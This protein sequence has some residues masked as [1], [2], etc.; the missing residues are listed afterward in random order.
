MRGAELALAAALVLSPAAA[1]A[2]SCVVVVNAPGA[3]VTNPAIDTMS[4]SLP[5]GSP[6][7][8]TVTTNSPLC[9][10]LGV[11]F[12]Y[13]VS[14][15]SPA[16]FVSAPGGGS[17]G[18]TFTTTYSVQ[19]GSLLFGLIPTTLLHGSNPMTIHLAATRSPGIFPAG[20]YR[21]EVVVRCE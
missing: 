7:S 17:T 4:S 20:S 19:S 5:G 3:M 13:K 12:C 8:V 14:V 18:V 1:R 21:A 15:Q 2:A 16:A 10:L 11:A 9:V 6:A